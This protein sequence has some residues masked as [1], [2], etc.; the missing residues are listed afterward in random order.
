MPR[1]LALVV[2]LSA[3][4]AV[5]KE[6]L[7]LLDTK[8]AAS[9]WA[10]AKVT[11]TSG[12]VLV[13]NY[14]TVAPPKVKRPAFQW[15]V[16]LKCRYPDRGD[17]SGLPAVDVLHSLQKLEV[18]LGAETNGAVRL[19]AKTGEST[20]EMVFQVK[21][22]V[23]FSKLATENA[24]KLALECQVETSQDPNWS[25]WADTVKKLSGT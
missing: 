22:K 5:S 12:S 1:L 15:R 2:L 25:M 21:D 9:D 13:V 24:E 18:T 14:R 23:T 19:M 7:H 6:P 17:A 10:V 8:S 20:R 4:Q 11:L 16:T 3:A